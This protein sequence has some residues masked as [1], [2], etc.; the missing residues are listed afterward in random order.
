LKLG[1]QIGGRLLTATHLDQSN[2]LANEKQRAASKYD[3]TVFIRLFQ[4]SSRCEFFQGH[5]SLQWIPWIW[6][7]APHP[8]FCISSKISSAGTH[9]ECRW[10][11]SYT[12]CASVFHGCSPNKKR[13]V[14]GACD[15]KIATEPSRLSRRMRDIVAAVQSDETNS[16]Q[17]T[18]GVG[19]QKRRRRKRKIIATTTKKNIVSAEQFWGGERKN[20][21]WSKEPAAAPRLLEEE[22]EEANKRTST[23][24][25][26]QDAELLKA[27]RCALRLLLLAPLLSSSRAIGE[28]VELHTGMCALHSCS[29]A[30]A[31]PLPL[32]AH[33]HLVWKEITNTSLCG[34]LSRS[35]SEP[36]FRVRPPKTAQSPISDLSIHPSIHRIW[37]LQ[38]DFID[39]LF[40]PIWMTFV[41][42]LKVQWN[43]QAPQ[44]IMLGKV[45]SSLEYI[46]FSFIAQGVSKENLTL[47]QNILCTKIVSFRS[48]INNHLETWTITFSSITKKLL[49]C[50]I[51]LFF[52]YVCV[53]MSMN[54]LVLDL[55]HRVWWH[56]QLTN[57]D[58]TNC[59]EFKDGILYYWE[60]LYI[61][62]GLAHLQILRAQLDFIVT[63]HIGFNRTLEFIYYDY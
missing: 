32:S 53:N 24:W 21:T 30:I 59:C 29:N 20:K 28:L 31:L 14:R 35:P 61:L 42:F 40:G 26:K 45:P 33:T 3:L 34:S 22:E 57:V 52:Y 38:L 23:P 47:Y 1:L 63:K 17:Q 46:I 41:F 58:E 13:N 9:S 49:R 39:L 37:V 36:C 44:S 62:D 56:N 6:L 10:R 18:N 4:G 16:Q 15:K 54:L 11:C 5:S 2:Y 55:E 12:P 27:V 50:W 60:L 8:R 19:R 51:Q 7:P 25:W 43:G 48:T